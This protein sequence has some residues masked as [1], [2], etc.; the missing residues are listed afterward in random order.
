MIRI[1]IACCLLAIG[2]HGAASSPVRAQ[3]ADPPQGADKEPGQFVE[4]PR[5][6]PGPVE[7]S[8]AVVPFDANRDGRLDLLFVNCNGWSRPGD[9]RAPSKDPLAPTLLINVRTENGLPVFEDQTERWIPKGFALFG[10]D[11]FVCDVDGD[12]HEDIVFSAAFGNQQRL[13]R[14]DP[15][16]GK[17]LDESQRLGELVLNSHS[18]GCGDLDD[19]GDLDLVFADAGEKSFGAPGGKARLLLNDGKGHFTDASSR[20]GAALKIGAQNPKIIDL[21]NDLDLD[22]VL[23]GKSPE[24]HFYRNDGHAN[25]TLDM[26]IVP[27]SLN[28]GRPYEIEWGDLDGD[29]D[30]D[31]IHMNYTGKRRRAFENATL[32]NHLSDQGKLTFTAAVESFEGNNLQDEND[33]ALLDTD[34]DGDLDVIAGVLPMLPGPEKLFINSGTFGPGFMKQ[35]VGAFTDIVDGTLDVDVGDFDGDGRYDVVTAQGESRRTGYD[36]RYYRNTGP[37]DT[38]PPTIGRVTALPKHLSPSAVMSGKQVIRAWIQDAVIDD[39]VTFVTARLEWE[40]EHGAS[41]AKGSS[42]MLSIGGGLHRAVLKLDSN[43]LEGVSS[44]K[45]ATLTVRVIATDG[46]G[47]SG[48]SAPQVIRVSAP[49]F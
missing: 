15:K 3:E 39:A 29:G 44:A 45:P 25:F 13:L 46:V 16:T 43:Q 10:K 40:L 20:L 11:A 28:G 26:A 31:G 1:L 6:L 41:K 5:L 34:N 32:E 21:D 18:L 9:M 33:F 47:N 48:E 37:R 30:L 8:E 7:W 38:R 19:D 14:K 17:Y 49:T 23:D 24:T 22:I 12:G 42:A 36:N 4:A 35:Q 27:P 2:L